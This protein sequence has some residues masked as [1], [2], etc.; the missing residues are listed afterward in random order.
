M[1]MYR[2]TQ[3]S[4]D[5]VA[6]RFYLPHYDR[7]I[8]MSL[9]NQDNKWKVVQLKSSIVNPDT[10]GNEINAHKWSKANLQWQPLN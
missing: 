4:K 10:V 5:K 6:Y 1:V 3:Q 2:E 7:M 9:Q 8:Q